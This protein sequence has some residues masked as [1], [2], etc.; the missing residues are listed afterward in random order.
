MCAVVVA[1]RERR[2]VPTNN[3]QGQ[4]VWDRAKPSRWWWVNEPDLV[5]DVALLLYD[6][7]GTPKIVTQL[8]VEWRRGA[9]NV[10]HAVELGYL[11]EREHVV[12]SSISHT[13][14]IEQWRAPDQQ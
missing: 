10:P 1:S 13:A 2:T 7:V 11:Q 6:N 5:V 12:S 8:L 3:E 4:N 14:A 9:G